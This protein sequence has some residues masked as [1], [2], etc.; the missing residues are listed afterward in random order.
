M[1]NFTVSQQLATLVA[2]LLVVF[3]I[4]TFLNIQS[5]KT[6][7][8]DERYEMLRTQVESGISILASFNDK[9]DAGELTTEEAKAQA[10]E[11]VTAMKYDPD[12]YLFGFTYD[13][14]GVF[15]TNPKIVGASLKDL[16]DDE[17]NF[18]V[19]DLVEVGR[20]GGGRV[21]YNWPKPG[22]PEGVT[23]P[24]GSYS[25]VFE[26]WQVVVGTGV[27]F[28]DLNAQIASNIWTFVAQGVV[29]TLFGI[30]LA[31]Y[32]IRNISKPL[33]SVREALD[34]VAQDNAEIKVPHTEM[35]NEIGNLARATQTLQ[36]KV[37]DRI[38]LTTQ[39]RQQQQELDQERKD[40]QADKE[41]EIAQQD[42]FLSEVSLLLARL[43]DGDLTIRCGDLGAKFGEF[44][45]NFNT[46]LMGLEQAMSDVSSKGGDIG[47]IKEQIR[48]ACKELS[49]RTE[50]QAASLEETSA[51]I[52]ELSATV[53]MTSDGANEAAERV[54]VVSQE[55]IQSDA[56]VKKAIEAMSDI[57]KSSDEISKIIGVIDEI[58]FQTNL[59]ALNAGVE[60]ARA[61]ESGKGFAVVAQEVRELAQRSA[62]AAKQIKQQISNSSGQ[63]Q[64]GVELVG[65][66]GEAL[67]RISDQIQSANEIVDKIAGSA[68]EQDITLGSIT[69]SVNE[70]DTQTQ[71]NAAMAEETTASA[72]L[73]SQDTSDL[74]HLIERFKV[75]GEINSVH[76]KNAARAA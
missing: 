63:V 28:D 41:Q 23:F 7:I 17:G 25:S 20:Q 36:E 27:Y 66:A 24:K 19:R 8:Y 12:G 62:D 67:A 29:I 1:K 50:I 39:Q 69:S 53:R 2:G 35:K 4:S 76:M 40:T 37:H 70:L 10:Y 75:S 56:I 13:S 38:N 74:L 31:A 48:V 9:V 14:V 32:I 3:G 30:G 33:N 51:A 55:T 49:Q 42:A 64:N 6:A 72:E 34:E 15:H 57:E 61:G 21:E 59:L 46:A 44:Q 58:A 43:A 71:N 16:K 47:D 73:L 60:A 11:A 5:T 52:E 18:F 68:K 22:S 26:P 65:Q 45:S 54:T